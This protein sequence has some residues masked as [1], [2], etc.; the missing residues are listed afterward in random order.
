L[1]GICLLF[2]PIVGSSAELSRCID[3]D[4]ARFIVNG[5]E[6]SVRFLAI[7]T[8][9]L[10]NNEFMAR[11]ASDFTCERLEGAD[12]IYLRADPLATNRDRYGRLLRWVYVDSVLLQ[13][14]LV[15]RGYARVAYIFDEYEYVDELRK[16]EEQA[17]QNRVGIYARQRLSA[18]EITLIVTS[19]MLVSWYAYV[20][21]VNRKAKTG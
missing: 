8:S 11:V 12:E 2:L 1:F 19:T 16:L 3:G 18:G 17:I 10:R 14:E 9:E 4:T 5:E 7:D 13:K 6:E 21:I 15:E 20:M